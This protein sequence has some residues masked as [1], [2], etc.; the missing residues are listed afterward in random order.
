MKKKNFIECMKMQEEE[1]RKL[2]AESTADLYRATRIHF[3]TFCL[4]KKIG[5]KD[6]NA[7]KVACFITYLKM[8]GLAV[9]SVNSYVSNLRA[10][11]NK[12]CKQAGVTPKMNPFE[13]IV[14]K[15]QET[16]KRA[17]SVKVIEK[18]AALDLSERPDLERAADLALFCFMSCG[19]PFVDLAHLTKA[20]IREGGK[21]LEYRR[22]KTN[23]LIQI[24]INPGMKFLLDKYRSSDNMYLF[25]ILSEETTHEQYK[26]SLARFNN[27]LKEIGRMLGLP[28]PFT[29]YVIR[30]SWASAAYQAHVGVSVISQGL[31]HTSE[32]MTRV[33]LTQIDTHELAKANQ[34]VIGKMEKIVL[35]REGTLI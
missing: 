6:V 22:R 9:N 11:Y 16:P 23:T 24:N 26:A 31:G 12:I 18:M 7:G 8:R 34:K 27:C 32:Q 29:S 17:V 10:M 15:R 33:Y 20:N 19:M 3:Y 30:H 13:G 1:K 35:S 25:P 5:L 21:K 28:E 2:G 14:L 4:G